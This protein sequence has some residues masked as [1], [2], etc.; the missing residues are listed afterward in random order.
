M[1]AVT[2]I[3]TQINR[4]KGEVDDQSELI[5]Q[6]AS[7]LEGKASG[8]GGSVSE[9]AQ[10]YFDGSD[11]ETLDMSR[12]IV[13]WSYDGDPCIMSFEDVNEQYC[14]IDPYTSMFIL[15]LD[16]SVRLET[17]MYNMSEAFY[18]E[19]LIDMSNVTILFPNESEQ[20][21]EFYRA[22]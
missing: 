5:D 6:I 12:V 4:I 8:G 11:V 16:S 13:V 15:N 17:N 21:I 7:V 19:G 3:Q 10:I 2:G 9:Y 14:D 20:Y 22:L 18:N 1:G